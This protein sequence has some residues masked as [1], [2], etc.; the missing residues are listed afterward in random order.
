VRIAHVTA[1]RGRS[2]RRPAPSSLATASKPVAAPLSA[3]HPRE[4][5]PDRF[6][7]S[8][9]IAEDLMGH[10][11]G[12]GGR[13]LKQ[14][15]DISSARVLAFTQ[16]VDGRSERLVSIWGTDKQISDALVVLGKRI[17]RKRVSAPKKKKYGTAPSVPVRCLRRLF[18]NPLPPEP[19]L[20]LAKRQ[21]LCEVECAPP[22]LHNP[23]PLSPLYRL[24]LLR[25]ELW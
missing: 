19:S 3:H 16:E 21:L 23:G 9:V 22:W 12:R 10:V 24:P 8:L 17:A 1:Q 7:A 18:Q 20:R 2:R 25:A 5:F 4:F 13:G 15:T 11:V 6:S 14:V